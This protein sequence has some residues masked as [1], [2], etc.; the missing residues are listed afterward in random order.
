MN[1]YLTMKELKEA[2]PDIPENSLKRYIQEHQEYLD[3]KKEHNRYIVH[4]SEIETLKLIRKLYSDGLKKEEVNA[5]LEESGI[6]LTITFDATE[7]QSLLSVN[8]ELTDMKKLVSF[9]VQQNEQSRLHQNK[10]KEQNQD[11]I[12]EVQE[13][14]NT[15]EEMREVQKLEYERETEKVS[16]ILESLL[17]TQKAIEE[18]AISSQSNRDNW[19]WQKVHRLLKK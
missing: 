7:N 13:L 11:L 1:Q 12:N 14:R 16:S 4:T 3:F 19:L 18:V 17:A 10:I 5:K 8:H 15:I 9:L 2:L 6:P